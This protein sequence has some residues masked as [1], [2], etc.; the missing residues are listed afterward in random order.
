MF[1]IKKISV[2]SELINPMR[3]LLKNKVKPILYISTFLQTFA[4]VSQSFL[5]K[6]LN[7]AIDSSFSFNFNLVI[8]SL[9][10]ETDFFTFLLNKKTSKYAFEF[11]TINSPKNKVIRTNVK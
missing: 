4:E 3:L 9:F 8:S 6:N 11:S 1:E 5:K 7:N 2:D 10:N